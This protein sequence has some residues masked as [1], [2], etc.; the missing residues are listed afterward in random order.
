MTLAHVQERSMRRGHIKL[1]LLIAAGVMPLL[2]RTAIPQVIDQGKAA[3]VKA[4][5]IYNFGKFV[6]WPDTA[7]QDESAPVVIGVIGSQSFVDILD[8]TVRGKTVRGR[9]LLV[10][11]VKFEKGKRVDGLR[12]CHIL[13]ISPSER[14]R[15][16]TI[17][18]ALDKASVLTVGDE[19]SFATNGGMIGLALRE[20]R[21]VFYVNRE[22]VKDAELKLSAKLLK[23]ARLV[24]SHKRSKVST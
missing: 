12:S 2:S 15:E 10:K 9:K 3:K 5:Y 17:L 8:D 6:T 16:H 24:R 18:R 23:L 13:Y 20:G 21:V 7:F 4:A 19:E 11:R 22:A 1:V 14:D